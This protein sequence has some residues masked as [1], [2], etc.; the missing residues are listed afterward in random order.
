MAHGINRWNFNLKSKILIKGNAHEKVVCEMSTFWA[1]CQ[2]LSYYDPETL[3]LSC[4]L[5]FRVQNGRM[6]EAEKNGR[7]FADDIF[8]CI[9]FN[10]S[11]WIPIKLWLKFVPKCPIS[12]I[13]ALFQ[14]MA[15]CR[16]GDRP[17]S[18]PMMFSLL[19]YASLSFNEL[20]AIGVVLL[21]SRD[22]A[23]LSIT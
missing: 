18:E 13:P 11:I 1:R 20:K 23:A 5:L 17:L 16:P 7:H 8:K 6:F 12:N 21:A 4:F 14:I 22:E 15:W 3:V 9:F 2:W 19:P 10:E